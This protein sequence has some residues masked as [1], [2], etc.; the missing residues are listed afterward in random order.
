MNNNNPLNA[1]NAAQKEEIF[2]RLLSQARDCKV[3]LG[4]WD[5]RYDERLTREVSLLKQSGYTDTLLVLSAL[6]DP[7]QMPADASLQTQPSKYEQGFCASSAAGSLV[8]YL[9]HLSNIDPIQYGL[10]FECFLY[11]KPQ[12]SVNTSVAWGQNAPLYLQHCKGPQKVHVSI[13]P[14]LD[15]VVFCL[16]AIEKQHNLEIDL[17]RIPLEAEVFSS[18][19]TEGKTDGVFQFSSSR[20]KEI[21]QELKPDC[22][23]DLILANALKWSKFDDAPERI[24]KAKRTGTWEASPLTEI[25]E[26]HDILCPTYGFLVYQEQVVQ[27]LA[28]LAGYSPEDAVRV[29]QDF[30]H[31]RTSKVSAERSVFLHGDASRK[32]SGCAGNGIPVETADRLFTLLQKIA[33]HTLSKS[34]AAAKSM[35]SYQT[36]WLKYHYCAE[37]SDAMADVLNRLF[38]S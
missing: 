5:S 23:E 7:A 12:F 34:H 21:L 25:P 16:E 10:R 11:A 14:V 13:L 26:L 9:L 32:I 35:V 8:C 4:Q 15:T 22:M 24:A 6:C 1:C 28:Q 38:F 36:A 37:L 19:Y 3:A 30:S 33:P 2:D 31:H 29:W 20:A 27:I 18:I 17:R